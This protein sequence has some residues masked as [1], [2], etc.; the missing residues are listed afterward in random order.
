MEISQFLC[1]A[2]SE[3]KTNSS[4]NIYAFCVFTSTIFLPSSVLTQDKKLKKVC[5]KKMTMGVE[6]NGVEV[7][8][9]VYNNFNF[10]L[11]HHSTRIISILS[12]KAMVSS[13]NSKGF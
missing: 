11:A 13:L 4:L 10:F 2:K 7:N 1:P 12:D 5:A 6:I 9:E 8:V 3:E